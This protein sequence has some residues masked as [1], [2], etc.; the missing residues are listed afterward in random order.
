MFLSVATRLA[1]WLTDF[2]I[3]VADEGSNR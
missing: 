3:E 1:A 2:S